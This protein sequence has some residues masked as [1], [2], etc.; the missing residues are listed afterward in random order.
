MG[1][2]ILSSTEEN[3]ENKIG[4]SYFCKLRRMIRSA[5]QVSLVRVQNRLIDF[6]INKFVAGP[7]RP[8]SR[9]FKFVPGPTRSLSRPS[10]SFKSN[11]QFQE[12]FALFS[13]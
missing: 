12:R 5:L 13:T 10:A 2:L 4:R 11:L 8:L 3:D 6:D 9:C 1:L 7:P